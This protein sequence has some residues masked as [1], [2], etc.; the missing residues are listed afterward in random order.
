[1]SEEIRTRAEIL[2]DLV[3]EARLNA[4]YSAAECSAVLGK[5]PSSYEALEKGDMTP[6]LQELEVLAVFLRVPMAHFWG[7]AP[8]IERTTMDYPNYL[9]LRQMMIGATLG[10][11]RIS[12]KMTVDELAAETGI[13]AE[14]LKVYESGAEPIPYFELETLAS[15]LDASIKV[16]V[17]DEYGPLAENEAERELEKRFS[18]WP[19]QMKMFIADSR[20]ISY[21]ETAMRLSEMDADKLRNIAE[22][23]LEITL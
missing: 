23:I 21:L 13:A 15:K 20:N 14:M 17:D 2:G 6:S 12:T 7:N 10:Q 4:G 22:G 8:V 9:A 11:V 3:R 1:M 19:P 18:E 5:T 16:F